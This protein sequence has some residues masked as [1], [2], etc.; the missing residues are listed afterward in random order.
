MI[1]KITHKDV[2]ADINEISD[3]IKSEQIGQKVSELSPA[4]QLINIAYK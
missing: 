3:Q 1:R 4:N 2:V